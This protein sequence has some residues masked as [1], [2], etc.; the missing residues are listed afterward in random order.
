MGLYARARRYLGGVEVGDKP[1]GGAVLGP[2]AG[3]NV[4]GHVRGLAYGN[5]ERP[6]LAQLVGKK[7]RKV[8]LARRRWNLVTVCI[9]G[10]RVDLNI[11]QEALK[12]IGLLLVRH[13]APL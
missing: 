10:L 1:K 11:A 8:K 3:G 6:Q 5:I 9:A 7:V 12:H 2:G 4:R 13:T